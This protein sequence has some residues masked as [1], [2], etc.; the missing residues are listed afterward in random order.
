MWQLQRGI[1]AGRGALDAAASGGS[2][3][4]GTVLVDTTASGASAPLSSPATSLAIEITGNANRALII[5]LSFASASPGT[6]TSV[7]VTFGG[8][9][10]TLIGG[11]VSSVG[12]SDMY[13]FGLINPTTT[14]SSVIVSWTSGGSHRISAGL[15][16]LHNVDQTGGTTT[17]RNFA[18]T[19]GSGTTAS[20][21]ITSDSGNIVVGGFMNGTNFGV[22]SHNSIASDNGAAIAAVAN[23]YNLAS[24]SSTN[25]GYAQSNSAFVAMGV[26]V[27]GV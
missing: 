10:A 6:V 1:I 27:K 5:F 18:Q 13:L 16:S 12:L 4:G 22:A 26:A 23:E 11:P 8:S 25:V 2:G 20:I 24:G 17:F 21:D 7:S 15:L 9:S 19:T 14:P 3:G